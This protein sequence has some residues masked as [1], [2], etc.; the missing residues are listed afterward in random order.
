[1]CRHRH[2]SLFLCARRYERTFLKTLNW[3]SPTSLS[4][5]M[6]TTYSLPPWRTTCAV[7]AGEEWVC[8]YT[9]NEGFAPVKHNCFDACRRGRGGASACVQH[10]GYGSTGHVAKQYEGW[11]KRN[12]SNFI[13]HQQ[14]A[15]LMRY[16]FWN[17]LQH[18]FFQLSWG[19][20]A[21][22]RGCVAVVREMGACTEHSSVRFKQR[23]VIEFLA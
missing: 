8:R 17:V 7:V 23:A 12:A 6:A 19:Q 16:K 1:M 15:T 11:M 21:V 10:Q 9:T 3:H 13:T 5:L 20:V 22:L 18:L 4:P 14:T 2:I